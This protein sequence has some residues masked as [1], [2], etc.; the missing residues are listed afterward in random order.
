M[1]TG[2]AVAVVTRGVFTVQEEAAFG[3]T[4][5]QPRPAPLPR[6]RT[7]LRAELVHH[8]PELVEVGLHLVVLQQGGGVWGRLGEVGHHGRDGD[9][10]APVVPQAAWLQAEAG[11]VPV[12]P[13]PGDGGRVRGSQGSAPHTDWPRGL[14]TP[15]EALI[16]PP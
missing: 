15:Q 7:H 4:D 6:H 3:R 9:L 13:F 10:A 11:R 1:A 12:L 2:I 14:L 16:P 8:V 5:P